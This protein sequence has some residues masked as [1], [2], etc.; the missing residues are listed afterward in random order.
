VNYRDWQRIYPILPPGEPNQNAAPSTAPRPR[1]A[2][3][4]QTFLVCPCCTAAA[5][6]RE[7]ARKHP[8]A[9]REWGRKG[10]R[11]P[12]VPKGSLIERAIAS[13]GNG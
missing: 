9:A 11:P 10:G 1:C 5:G 4:T 8:G 3:H 7:T 12:K 2:V 13:A 6:G